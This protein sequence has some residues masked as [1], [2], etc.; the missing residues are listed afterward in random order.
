MSRSYVGLSHLLT[1]GK[2]ILSFEGTR[3]PA[4]RRI[5]S[6]YRSRQSRPAD[7]KTHHGATAHVAIGPAPRGPEKPVILPPLRA[8]LG[9]WYYGHMERKRMG[10]SM[11][12]SDRGNKAGARRRYRPPQ[13]IISKSL[14]D[15]VD[16]CGRGSLEEKQFT[17]LS[18]RKDDPDVDVLYAGNLDL[19]KRPAVSIVGT[20]NV[21]DDGRQRARRLARRSA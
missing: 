7:L 10:L 20:R 21:T 12:A 17:L 13:S 19:L 9:L 8:R 15:L 3:I 16:F 2:E 6:G 5:K 1:A 4:P 11:Y 18:G 14:R